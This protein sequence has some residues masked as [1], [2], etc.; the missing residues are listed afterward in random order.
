MCAV[1]DQL[2]FL[3]R[4]ERLLKGWVSS[5]DGRHSMVYNYEV[6]CAGCGMRRSFGKKSIAVEC[7]EWH[8]C[9]DHLNVQ[10]A[11]P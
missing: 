10:S 8:S 3:P 9:K 4:V 6:S 2:T 1:A 7:A 11:F 5:P